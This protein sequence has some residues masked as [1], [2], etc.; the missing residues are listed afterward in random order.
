MHA[1]GQLL[2]SGMCHVLHAWQPL[3]APAWRQKQSGWPMRV[4]KSSVCAQR[5]LHVTLG[6]C[7]SIHVAVRVMLSALLFSRTHMQHDGG[8]HSHSLII[9]SLPPLHPFPHCPPLHP[10]AHPFAPAD[11]VHQLRFAA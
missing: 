10:S 6:E 11:V 9:P 2:Q 8:M 3:G 7:A 4:Q 5:G 1:H